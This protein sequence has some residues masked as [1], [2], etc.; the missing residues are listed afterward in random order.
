MLHCQQRC[1]GDNYYLWANLSVVLPLKDLSV[2]HERLTRCRHDTSEQTVCLEHARNGEVWNFGKLRTIC[3]M[4]KVCHSWRSV[5][6][7]KH[8]HFV[9]PISQAK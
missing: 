2:G 8:T 4:Q 6:L 1:V 3:R 9:I 5:P 7:K